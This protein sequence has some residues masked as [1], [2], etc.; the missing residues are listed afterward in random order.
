MLSRPGVP[1]D[2]KGQHGA[3]AGRCHG[4]LGGSRSAQCQGVRVV[5]H[6]DAHGGNQHLGEP[7]AGDLLS[8]D[9]GPADHPDPLGAQSTGGK[10]DRL[11]ERGG[12]DRALAPRTR[13]RR[14]ARCPCARPRAGAG[15]A[16]TTQ[17]CRPM[18]T[19]CPSVTVR[20]WARPSGNDY[21]SPPSV[22]KTPLPDCAQIADSIG[23]STGHEVSR[24]AMGRTLKMK[25]AS[26]PSCEI[27]FIV[28]GPLT[29]ISW[30]KVRAAAR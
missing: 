16:G 24:E 30:A 14:S 26:A 19:G 15:P 22:P 5:G 20:K 12:G 25:S 10:R 9:G 7:G 29:I 4:L 17:V 2:P 18:K 11:F 6:T 27:S 21:G 3:R 8:A 1:V 23:G 28:Q 13:G